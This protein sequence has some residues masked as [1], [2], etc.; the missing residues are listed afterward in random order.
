[1]KEYTAKELS[2]VTGGT[3]LDTNLDNP[4]FKF[5]QKVKV[6]IPGTD[7]YFITEINGIG[8]GYVPE[9]QK[10]MVDVVVYGFNNPYTGEF[11][12]TPAENIT[13]AE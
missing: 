12:V 10:H 5:G 2:A 8:F 9:G 11:F 6:R 13:L 1:M 7:E 4:I 3:R